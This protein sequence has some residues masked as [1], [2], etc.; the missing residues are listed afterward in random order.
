MNIVVVRRLAML[1]LVAGLSSIC[2]MAQGPIQVT[3]PFDFTIG[4][5]SFPSGD[6]V[7]RPDMTHTVLAIQSVDGQSAAMALTTPMYGHNESGGARLIFNRYGD[8]YFLSQVW[9]GAQGRELPR[10]TSERELIAKT[11]STKSVALVASSRE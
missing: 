3:I 6:Y 10:S 5:K 9:N 11:K 2:L 1:C 8:R 7:V 4:S